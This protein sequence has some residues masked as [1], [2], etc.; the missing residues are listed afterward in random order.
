MRISRYWLTALLALHLGLVEVSKKSFAQQDSPLS[1]NSYTPDEKLLGVA[2][3][4]A[5]TQ[6]HVYQLGKDPKEMAEL[7]AT[8]LK[9]QLGLDGKDLKSLFNRDDYHS[10]LSYARTLI[11]HNICKM[12]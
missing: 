11:N 12:K 4:M 7:M 5:L 9:Q 10:A 2:T 3:V 1:Q 6:C 8:Y